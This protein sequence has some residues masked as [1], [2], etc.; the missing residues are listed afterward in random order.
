MAYG[1]LTYNGK[2]IDIAFKMLENSIK[3]LT[4]DKQYLNII[5]KISQN[6]KEMYD[7]NGVNNINY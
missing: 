6:R 2:N 3:N 1:M 4:S 7:E 5:N